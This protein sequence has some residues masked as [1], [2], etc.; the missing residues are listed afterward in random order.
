MKLTLSLSKRSAVGDTTCAVAPICSESACEKV[1]ENML[2]FEQGYTF[3][4][5]ISD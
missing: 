3:T 2:S 5:K 1:K 4:S